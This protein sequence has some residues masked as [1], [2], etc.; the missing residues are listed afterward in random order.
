MITTKEFELNQD[1]VN[2]QINLLLDFT[3]SFAYYRAINQ[4]LPRVQRNIP[5]WIYSMNTHYFRAITDWCIVFGSDNNNKSHW[6]NVSEDEKRKIKLVI[7]PLVLAAA[8]FTQS[9]WDFYRTELVAFRNNYAAHR[10]VNPK[11]D[12]VPN[13]DNAFEIAKSYSNWLKGSL[14][15]QNQVLNSLYDLFLEFQIEV[16][17]VLKSDF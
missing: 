14:N 17:G 8:N 7:R 11:E 6:K 3:Q 9:E 12:R 13:L 15:M 10:N 16:L 2:I 1:I 4:D 5:F